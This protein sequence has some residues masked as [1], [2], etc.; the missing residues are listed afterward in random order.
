MKKII[1]KKKTAPRRKGLTDIKTQIK[2]VKNQIKKQKHSDNG[3]KPANQENI[4]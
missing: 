2:K 3:K 4:V 1:V